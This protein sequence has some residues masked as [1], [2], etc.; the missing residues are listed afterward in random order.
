MKEVR[1]LRIIVDRTQDDMEE[2]DSSLD[3]AIPDHI[4]FL[5]NL[6]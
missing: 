5:L 2:R 3:F 6:F 1:G 4:V